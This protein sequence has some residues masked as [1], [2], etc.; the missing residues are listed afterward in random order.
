MAVEMHN[1]F[2]DKVVSSESM[3]NSSSLWTTTAQENH[4]AFLQLCF[5]EKVGGTA[6]GAR[7]N[8]LILFP[9]ALWHA[10]SL[11]GENQD[12]Y[13]SVACRKSCLA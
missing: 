4:R 6:H 9:G 11:S 5:V 1:D 7:Q 8:N 10:S 13:L 2:R 3:S 12:A